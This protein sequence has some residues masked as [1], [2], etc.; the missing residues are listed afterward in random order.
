MAQ[1]C[2]VQGVVRGARHTA[3]GVRIS[4]ASER[5]RAVGSREVTRCIQAM[6]STNV[7][8]VGRWLRANCTT[9]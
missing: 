4:T 3:V 1:A 6:A 2:E 5:D 8:T 9:R 7:T